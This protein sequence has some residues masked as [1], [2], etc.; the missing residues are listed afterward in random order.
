MT[1]AF[2]DPLITEEKKKKR[3]LVVCRD[4]TPSRII[5]QWIRLVSLAVPLPR[6]SEKD[7][8]RIE[9]SYPRR[10][11]QGCVLA[12]MGFPG[13]N[14]ERPDWQIPIIDTEHEAGLLSVSE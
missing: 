11:L 4:W 9:G 3:D 12:K 6:A 14:G 5:N 7:R 1:R 10:A 8:S 2:L 13:L